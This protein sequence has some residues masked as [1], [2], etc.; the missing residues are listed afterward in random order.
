MHPPI[1]PISQMLGGTAGR[2]IGH[3][4]MTQM[5]GG[6]AGRGI[7][8]PPISQMTQMLGGIAGWYCWAGKAGKEVEHSFL[9]AQLHVH[10]HTG[11]RDL[12]NGPRPHENYDHMDD[13]DPQTYAILGA[14]MEVHSVLGKGFLESVYHEA[15]ALELLD[16]GIPFR[17]E[18]QLPIV[19]KGT[20]LRTTFRCDL[21]C[22]EDV[23]VELKAISTLTNA[24][25][26]QLINYLTA[27]RIGR[28]LVINFGAAS[29]QYKRRV[30]SWN[31]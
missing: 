6:I 10:S 23:V 3:P 27:A 19:Y 25:E 29:L 11:R 30:K 15:L 14:A 28:G 16:R 24:D 31:G 2:V 21:I 20:R 18:V 7:G 22:F 26:A 12:L 1:T 13:H 4:P 17:Q 5:L 9:G 8:H